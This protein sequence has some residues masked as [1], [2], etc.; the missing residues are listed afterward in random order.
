M[1]R[2]ERLFESIEFLSRQ[3]NVLAASLQYNRLR[4][5][6]TNNS[7]V[8]KFLQDYGALDSVKKRMLDKQRSLSDA[9]TE[10]LEHLLFM[11]SVQSCHSKMLAIDKACLSRSKVQT[12]MEFIARDHSD[13][14]RLQEQVKRMHLRDYD[15][16]VRAQTL[17]H[18]YL[19][20]SDQ[21]ESVVTSG[22]ISLQK[23][24]KE[25]VSK[26]NVAYLVLLVETF[27]NISTSSVQEVRQ[28]VLIMISALENEDGA[29]HAE[30]VQQSGPQLGRHQGQNAEES[31]KV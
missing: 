15:D 11:D 24:R 9:V 20:E 28:V 2:V 7:D 26:Q 29:G 10:D 16:A 18:E 14:T 6:V 21:H 31:T 12:I 19:K 8:S 3:S 4:D 17:I 30:I 25:A 5:V 23:E 1:N 13:A 22:L 27:K